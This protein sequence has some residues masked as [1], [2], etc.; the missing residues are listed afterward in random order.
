[1]YLN[2]TIN[3]RFEFPQKKKDFNCK[4]QKEEEKEKEIML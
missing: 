2:L 1:M 3:K 4:P